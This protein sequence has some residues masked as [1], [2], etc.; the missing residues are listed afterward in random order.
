MGPLPV[1]ASVDSPKPRRQAAAPVQGS[2]TPRA[3]GRLSAAAGCGEH[4]VRWSPAVTTNA[5]DATIATV[6]L[7][8]RARPRLR[9]P[10]G[11]NAIA[12]RAPEHDDR[13]DS[14]VAFAIAPPKRA[15][16]KGVVPRR[17]CAR[18]D[19][20]ESTRGANLL[21]C[22]VAASKPVPLHVQVLH[23]AS[24]TPGRRRLLLRLGKR[25][26]RARRLRR[27][28]VSSD[29][30]ARSLWPRAARDA[31]RSG[32]RAPGPGTHFGCCLLTKGG[33]ER[34]EWRPPSSSHRGRPLGLSPS[35]P[36]GAS[37]RCLL[38]GRSRAGA[39]CVT[40]L[41]HRHLR[42]HGRFST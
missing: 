17:G 39:T 3:G 38:V 13:R 28:W 35:R 14:D 26:S 42:G 32:G 33:P 9:R 7:R 2:A 1:H 25:A 6:A 22:D 30:A 24:A 34:G 16:T 27:C 8:N 29:P 40:R 31:W 37:A 15:R 4:T 36:S 41:P 19:L 21:D 20:G 5:G 10:A 18:L 23:V 11:T 12:R